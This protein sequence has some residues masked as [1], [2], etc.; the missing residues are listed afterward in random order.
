MSHPKVRRWLGLSLFGLL[1]LGIGAL[2]LVTI[3][4]VAYNLLKPSGAWNVKCLPDEDRPVQRI[5]GPIPD[6]GVSAIA[7]GGNRSCAL[8]NA[9]SVWCW[10]WTDVSA[11]P[12]RPHAFVNGNGVLDETADRDGE[13]LGNLKTGSIPQRAPRAEEVVQI[14]QHRLGYCSVDRSA[15][16]RCDAVVAHDGANPAAYEPTIVQHDVRLVVVGNEHA[17]AL[18]T[19]GSAWC[20]GRNDWG[21]LGLP[22]HA[23]VVEKPA[24]VRE[25]VQKITIGL[26]HTCAIYE[27]SSG[28][29]LECWGNDDLGQLGNW[30]ARSDDPRPVSVTGSPSLVND[31]DF[32]DIA[33]GATH[34]CALTRDGA[35]WCW[36][37]DTSRRPR[38]AA[39]RPATRVTGLTTDIVKL[40]AGGDATCALTSKGAIYCW[41]LLVG[42]PRADAPVLLRAPAPAND[43]QLGDHHVC[44]LLRSS[45]VV[46]QGADQRHQLG[47]VLPVRESTNNYTCR[48]RQW[49]EEPSSAEFVPVAW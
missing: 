22:P 21:Q 35:V 34:T 24:R 39:G 32:N 31:A 3:A 18:D 19:N 20:W 30:S 42:R 17:C 29:R 12:G 45:Q 10:G 6:G 1:G 36:G 4:L 27:V 14:A 15:V 13:P 46:C 5:G 40:A 47:A 26:A 43:V 37:E 7:I 41:G 48:T 23:G 25:R 28:T 49:F 11:S 9:G 16:L 44:A 8:T 38:A 2:L 33:A